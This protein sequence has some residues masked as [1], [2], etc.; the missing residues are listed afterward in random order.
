MCCLDNLNS[1]PDVV[2]GDL[3]AYLFVG[4]QGCRSKLVGDEALLMHHKVLSVHFKR[5]TVAEATFQL[6]GSIN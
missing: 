1:I 3:I 5:P 2:F 4:A 6:L